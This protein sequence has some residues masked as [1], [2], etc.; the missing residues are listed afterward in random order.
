MLL[1]LGTDGRRSRASA[2]ATEVT[3]MAAFYTSPLVLTRHRVILTM[4][5]EMN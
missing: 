3:W 5:S 2:V 1:A 4:K